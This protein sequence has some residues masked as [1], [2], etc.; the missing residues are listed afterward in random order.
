[1]KTSDALLIFS[2]TLLWSI[3]PLFMKKV[4]VGSSPISVTLMVGAC[5]AFFLPLLYL[6]AL[7]NNIH[8]N[9]S[10]QA[11]CWAAGA[12]L[13]NML[14]QLALNKAMINVPVNISVALTSCYPLITFFL[15]YMFLHETISILKIVGTIL[16]VGGTICIAI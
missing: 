14:A 9:F 4:L 5:G 8:V 1:M 12:Y 3:W 15:C 6:F 7:K 2:T 11:L 16:I 10:W 13:I